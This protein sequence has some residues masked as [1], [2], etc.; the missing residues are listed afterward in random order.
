MVSAHGADS[1]FPCTGTGTFIQP[2]ATVPGSTI[3][4]H[5]PQLCLT[6]TGTCVGP[7]DKDVQAPVEPGA[8]SVCQRYVEW[9]DEWTGVWYRNVGPASC[10]SVPLG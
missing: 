6:T 5:V 7:V 9:Y 3:H 8:I 2:F 10:T 4:L 1:G